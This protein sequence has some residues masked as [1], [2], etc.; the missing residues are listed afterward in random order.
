L[1]LVCRSV[2]ATDVDALRNLLHASPALH[3]AE[4]VAGLMRMRTSSVTVLRCVIGRTVDDHLALFQGFELLDALF[5]V[6]KLQGTQLA[7]YK[8]RTH[9]VIELQLFRDQTVGMLSRDE[10]LRR[11][12]AELKAAYQWTEEPELLEPI[13][14]A[15][16]RNVYSGF[17]VES[18][19]VRVGTTCSVP[20]LYFAGDW[21][22]PDEGAWYMERAVRSGRLAARAILK[23][24]GERADK[25]PLLPPVRAPWQLRTLA[26]RGGERGILAVSRAILALLDLNDATAPR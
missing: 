22:Q 6:T 18:E 24:E 23:A 4:D 8:G 25:V 5:N 16:N 2:G 14:L 19:S 15:F 12:R 9:E 20:G 7:R 3:P 1:N 21:V 26:R 11:V 17:D 13:H 10:I